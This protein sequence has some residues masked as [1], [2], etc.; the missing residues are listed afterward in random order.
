MGFAV[1]PAR[2]ASRGS[3]WPPAPIYATHIPAPQRATLTP[4]MQ[5]VPVAAL[6][7][8]AAVM[9]R[10]LRQ[11]TRVARPSMVRRA[12]AHQE[13]PAVHRPSEQSAA[14]LGGPAYS[15]T[16]CSPHSNQAS[17]GFRSL[18]IRPCAGVARAT[19]RSAAI[20]SSNK[21]DLI[22]GRHTGAGTA[23]RRASQGYDQE[24]PP[25]MP[26]STRCSASCLL[27]QQKRGGKFG[28]LP[29][30][31]SPCHCPQ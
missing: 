2:P 13:A 1:P 29:S 16:V 14:P 3:V 24:R 31:P 20:R 17:Q 7:V 28:T 26:S 11:V 8:R 4:S 18:K 5:L 19:A 15:G 9:G 12:A 27:P 30:L 21:S 25:S 22:T 10:A 6:R 23:R